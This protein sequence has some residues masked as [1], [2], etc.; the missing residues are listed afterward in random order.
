MGNVSLCKKDIA[1]LAAG[2]RHTNY[3][4]GSVR[5]ENS[6]IFASQS[7]AAN[8]TIMKFRRAMKLLVLSSLVSCFIYIVVNDIKKLFRREIGTLF[9]IVS[10][11][12]V[13]VR[14]NYNKLRSI[15]CIT[16]IHLQ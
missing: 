7:L 4:R 6:L 13:E 12:T 9:N 8:A 14:S 2:K 3:R 10:Q 15:T 5:S 1:G 11:D 16:V